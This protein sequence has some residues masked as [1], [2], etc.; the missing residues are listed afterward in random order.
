MQQIVECTVNKHI[1]HTHTHT[2]THCAL[3]IDKTLGPNTIS[4]KNIFLNINNWNVKLLPVL[5]T[6]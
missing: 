6:E 4:V 1:M 3:K 5:E 2:L